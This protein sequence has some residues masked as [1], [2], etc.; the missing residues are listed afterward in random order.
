MSLEAV[1]YSTA[2]MDQSDGLNVV[3]FVSTLDMYV[4]NGIEEA[5]TRIRARRLAER[6]RSSE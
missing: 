3:G 4:M 5:R 1:D 6:A 2:S